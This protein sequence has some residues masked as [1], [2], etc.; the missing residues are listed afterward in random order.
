MQ[1]KRFVEI[2]TVHEKCFFTLTKIE[3]VDYTHD[4]MMNK[5]WNELFIFV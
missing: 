3:T 1:P 5:K 2:I 4:G